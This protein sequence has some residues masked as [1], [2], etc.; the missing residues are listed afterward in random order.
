MTNPIVAVLLFQFLGAASS[1]AAKKQTGE[2]CTFVKRTI[3][4][5]SILT[6]RA[7]DSEPLHHGHVS[8]RPE[9][10]NAGLVSAMCWSP[11]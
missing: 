10:N 11:L 5:T 6:P 4:A 3:R 7:H 9:V 2:W 1:H 8:D